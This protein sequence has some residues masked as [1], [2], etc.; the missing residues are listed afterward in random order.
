MTYTPRQESI[1]GADLTGAS[2]DSDRTYHLVNANSVFAQM[3]IMVQGVVLQPTVHFTHNA[4]TDVITLLNDVWDDQDI[5]IDYL[6]EDTVPAPE[7]TNYCIT[8]QIARFCGLGVEVQAENLGTGDNSET[9]YNTKHGNV[10]DDSYKLYYG[11]SGSND[12]TDLVI[13]TDYSIVKDSGAILL[14]SAGKTKVNAKVIYI[15]YTYSPKQSDTVLATYIPGASREAEKLTNDYY[16]S[17]QTSIEYFDG[18]DSGYPHTDRPFGEQ[19]DPIH[20][21]ELSKKSITGITTVEFL[22]NV[23]DVDTTVDSDYISYSDNGRVILTA[24]TPP[25]GKRNIKITFTHG[26]DAV[27]ALIQELSALIAGKMALVNIS[28][29]SYK[30]I[31]TYSLGR[32]SFSIGQIYVNIDNSIKQMQKR[33]DAIVSG[34]GFKYSCA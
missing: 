22:D 20:E 19:I 2:G 23:G 1:T 21:F 6:T 34:L 24:N 9:S 8:L 13:S 25:N 30:D 31:S 16:G 10:L 33:I 3:R 26:E 5:S 28:G 17:E 32:K 14:T 27:P 18:H 4:D 15:D 7:G 12:T 11:A 29:G